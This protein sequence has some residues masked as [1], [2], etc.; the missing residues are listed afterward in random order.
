MF[1]KKTSVIYLKKD[2]LKIAVLRLG[3]TPKILKTDESDWTKE[4]LTQTLDQVKSQ[5]PSKTINLV[6]SD[7]L[8]KEEHLNHIK[9][10]LTKADLSI[11]TIQS[12]S[13]VIKRN[14]DPLI[15]SVLPESEVNKASK[16]KQLKEPSLKINKNIVI[17]FLITLFIGILIAGGIITQN[18]ALNK[19]SLIILPSPSLS[20]QNT[21]LSADPPVTSSPSLSTQNTNLSADPLPSLSPSDYEILIINGTGGRGIAS[22][23]KDLLEPLKFKDIQTSNATKFDFTQTEIQLKNLELQPIFEQISQILTPAYEVTISAELLTKDSDYDVIITVG[24][25][26]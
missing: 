13:T 2:T 25:T 24:E 20:T 9:Q 23:V 10:S 6:L 26:I 19:H 22:A 4:S 15:G 12:E 3:K 16:P 21:N 8:L 7:D 18:N 5:L 17:I 1:H 14:Q 11:E